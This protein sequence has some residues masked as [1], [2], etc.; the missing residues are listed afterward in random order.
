MYSFQEE[1]FRRE[2]CP[3][4]NAKYDVNDSGDPTIDNNISMKYIPR[5][6]TN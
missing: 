3:L 5:T 2:G 1:G 6:V 4:F